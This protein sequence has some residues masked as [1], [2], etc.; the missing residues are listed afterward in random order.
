MKERRGNFSNLIID[1]RIIKELT[2]VVIMLAILLW[3]RIR[4]GG[5]LLKPPSRYT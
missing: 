4:S 2:Q 1:V 5:W 3:L